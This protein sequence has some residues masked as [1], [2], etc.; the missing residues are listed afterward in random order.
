MKLSIKGRY[1]A[2]AML[3]LALIEKK[4]PIQLKKLLE[5]KIFLSA[6]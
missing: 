2:R 4:G 6:I 5:N 3:E 1:A